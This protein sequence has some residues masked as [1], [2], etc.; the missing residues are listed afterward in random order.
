M[1]CGELSTSL[2]MK[3]FW[4]TFSKLHEFRNYVALGISMVH[5]Q[6]Y[7]WFPEGLWTLVNQAPLF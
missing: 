1:Q 4:K 7:L 6:T 3:G 2:K 5:I